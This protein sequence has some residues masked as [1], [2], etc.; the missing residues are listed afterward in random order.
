[1]FC[2]IRDFTGFS[3]LLS[4]YDVMFVLNRFFHQMGEVIERNG[5]YID[6][7]IG[8]GVM[9]LFGI[10]EMGLDKVDLQLLTNLC[11]HFDGGP[12]GLS[13]LAISVGE[14]TETVEDVIEPFLIQ[15]G[16]LK[17]TPRGRM[18]TPA[19]WRH[20]GYEPPAAAPPDGA[21]SLFT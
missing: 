17:R 1:M 11:R 10:D 5:G 12:V 7:F 16:L 2:D 13:N 3:E 4:P 15:Q 6:K 20:I 14:P 19:A 21:P 9:A 8:D 18:A